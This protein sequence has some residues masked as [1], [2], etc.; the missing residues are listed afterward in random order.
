MEGPGLATGD[1]EGENRVRVGKRYTTRQVCGTYQFVPILPMNTCWLVDVSWVTRMEHPARQAD[2]M[3]LG[4]GCVQKKI[5]RTT[6]LLGVSFHA[7][8]TYEPTLPSSSSCK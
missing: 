8:I 1:L 4:M 5:C 3:C 6:N 2:D 7:D